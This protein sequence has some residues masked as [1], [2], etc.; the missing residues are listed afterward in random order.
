[1]LAG[2][3]SERDYWAIRPAEVGRLKGERWN[4]ANAHSPRQQ[5]RSQRACAPRGA[6]HGPPRKGR[7]RRV[8]LLTNELGLFHGREEMERLDRACAGGR[9]RRRNAHPHPQARS[10]GLCSAAARRWALARRLSSSSTTRSATSRLRSSLPASRRSGFDVTRPAAT[11]AEVERRLGLPEAR[12][13]RRRRRRRQ[14]IVAL[15][16]GIGDERFERIRI[17]H[18]VAVEDR[19][20]EA[21][22]SNPATGTSI[23]LPVRV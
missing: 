21:P 19:I 13:R 16:R 2:S 10:A 18:G 14:R 11:Y 6:G 7:G 23:F 12:S 20:G 22:N 8:G 4:I 15:A 1:M 9:G 5:S 3:I 17:G